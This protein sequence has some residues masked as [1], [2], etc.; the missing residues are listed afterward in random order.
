MRSLL[1]VTEDA[2]GAEFCRARLDEAGLVAEGVALGARPLPYRLE[3][4]LA[5]D[6]RLVTRS[7]RMRS[8]GDTWTRELALDHDG[9]G[10]WTCRAGT[11]GGSDLPPAGGDAQELGGALDVDIGYSPLTNTMP[12]LRE[13]VRAADRSCD[14]VAAWVS[15][16]ALAVIPSQQRYEGLARD[17]VRYRSGSFAATLE[18]DD[19]GFVRRYPGLARRIEA[20]A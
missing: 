14:I 19:D 10:S 6:E 7:V 9:A 18:L 3:Y 8:T 16:P 2:P 1:W 15:V 11:V 4:D 20:R 5:T 17:R 13:D 12:I